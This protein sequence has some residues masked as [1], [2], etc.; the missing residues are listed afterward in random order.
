MSVYLVVL[1]IT[2]ALLIQSKTGDQ[3]LILFAGAVMWASLYYPRRVYLAMALALVLVGVWVVHYISLSLPASMKTIA[4]ITVVMVVVAELFYR[5]TRRRL[6]AEA[7]MRES[8]ARYRN[9]VERANDGIV[10]VS[11]GMIRY[12]NPQMAAMLDYPTEV[13][14]GQPFAL[15]I[16]PE[17]R[18]IVIGRYQRRLLGELVPERYEISLIHRDGHLVDVEI[19]AGTI[20]DGACLALLAFVR[21]ITERRQTE[22][23]T[24]ELSVEKER[25]KLLERFIG[26]ASHD[27]KTPLTTMK[28][29]L[30]VLQK[31][32]DSQKRRRHLEILEAQALH[33]ERLLEDLLNMTRLDRSDAIECKPVEVCKLVREVL[34]EHAGLIEGKGHTV[35]FSP[36]PSR[37]VMPA[38]RDGLKRAVD[39]LVTNAL[40]YT[41]DGGTIKVRIGVRLQEQ[42]AVIEVQDTG[43]GIG[44]MD[45]PRIFE[46]FYRADRAR[47]TVKGG[48][49]LGL[50]IAKKIVEAHGGKIEVE[51]APGVGSM[52]R[53]VLPVNSLRV[54]MGASR[55]GEIEVA[56]RP[57][58][59]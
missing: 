12:C 17:Y 7:A 22:E 48:T 37:F 27:L 42:Q 20:E 32:A 29:S 21:D 52:F 44:E 4:T 54:A 10:V 15:Y 45:L 38:D 36:E 35:C 11:D 55:G 53:I 34:A 6:R 3:F 49:G 43:I 28:V 30:A 26:D 50:S 23:R 25:V 18:A 5:L 8:E 1:L 19:S 33:L 16:A 13:L 59:R 24:L 58:K 2:G 56:S 47:S 40:N 39:A 51:S 14:V 41:P 46:R 9:V 31:T 57:I